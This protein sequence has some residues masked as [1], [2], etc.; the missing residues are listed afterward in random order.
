MPEKQLVGRDEWIL[1]SADWRDW[2]DIPD[3][4]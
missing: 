3:G 1:A 4:I 2:E